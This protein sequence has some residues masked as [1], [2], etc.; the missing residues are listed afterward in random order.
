M[1]QPTVLI[2]GAGM[3]G[4]SAARKLREHHYKILILEARD[5]IGGRTWSEDFSGI[6]FDLGAFM[7]HGLKGNPLAT[8]AEEHN[9]KLSQANTF[10]KDFGDFEKKIPN[11]TIDNAY[12]QFQQLIQEASI[13]ARQL[14]KDIS[15]Y[16]AM[17]AVFSLAKYPEL[18]DKLYAWNHHFFSLYTAIGAKHVSASHWDEDEIA[19]EGRQPL[20]LGGYRSIVNYL[21][22]GLPI[23]LSTMVNHIDYYHDK[24]KLTTNKGNYEANAVLVT[25]PLGVLK[26]QTIQFSPPLPVNKIQSIKNLGMGIS[27]RIALKFPEVFWPEDASVL[28]TLTTKYTTISWFINY[29][30]YTQQPVLVG[31]MS[32]EIAKKLEQL[33]DKN[34]L[35]EVMKSLRHLYGKQIPEPSAYIISRWSQDPYAFGSY[36]YIPVGASGED[37]DVLAQNV[38]NKLFFAGEA[39]NRRFPGT[40]HG[41]YFSGIREAENI[42][43]HIK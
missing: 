25:V 8:I 15:L 22:K 28:T 24:V 19:L 4:L 30:L 16:E 36:S 1:H 11:Q 33:D 18:N 34:L 42:I 38:E 37:Y 5:R 26:N 12:L 3:A 14:K 31:V 41:A 32:G 2:I 39:T 13:Y 29:Y 35:K 10:T 43:Y 9:I 27:D 40:V 23:Q 20:V 6:P 21:A 17:Q 7:F